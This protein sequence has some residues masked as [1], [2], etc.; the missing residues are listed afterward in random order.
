MNTLLHLKL[1][2]QASES[3]ILTRSSCVPITYF[4]PCKL[5]WVQNIFHGKRCF[6]DERQFGFSWLHFSLQWS[7]KGTSNQCWCLCLYVLPL[8]TPPGRFEI[9]MS[10]KKIPKWS[11]A[12]SRNNCTQRPP[13]ED[14]LWDPR[15]LQNVN[16]RPQGWGCVVWCG[17][18]WWGSY[19]LLRIRLKCAFFLSARVPYRCLAS[20][21]LQI[22][23]FP[24]LGHVH[25]GCY[26]NLLRHHRESFSLFLPC[27]P[28]FRVPFV[29]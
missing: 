26:A 4:F 17:V 16:V 25:G 23:D 27:I 14:D 8:R 5:R 9:Y 29:F 7:A 19:L 10:F 3:F 15:V 12:S 13:C 6:V 28:L 11:N 24:L 21:C 2:S 20:Y 22:G 1:N 18:V